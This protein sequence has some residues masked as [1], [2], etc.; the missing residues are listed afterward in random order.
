[1][2]ESGF[3][4]IILGSAILI[5]IIYGFIVRHNWNPLKF[6]PDTFIAMFLIAFGL[7]QSASSYG[8]F[9][10]GAIVLLMLPFACAISNNSFVYKKVEKSSIGWLV[11]GIIL[12]ALCFLYN[13]GHRIFG[14]DAFIFDIIVVLFFAFSVIRFPGFHRTVLLLAFSVWSTFLFS[15]AAL[16]SSYILVIMGTTIF[17]RSYFTGA[18]QTFN[19][20]DFRP[21]DIIN[22]NMYPF[23]ILD[24]SGRIIYANRDFLDFS[25]YGE[26]DLIGKEAIE[27]IEIP[28]NWMLKISP[29]GGRKKIRCHLLCRD[30]RRLPI[31]LW[32]NEIKKHGKELKN[33]ICFIY[34]ESEHQAMELK[35]N[36][37]AR[38]FSGLH[39]TSRAISSSLEMK[40]VL[41]AIASAAEALTDSDTCTV[42]MLDHSKQVVKP[43]YS[44]EQV[45]SDE[46][47]NFEF[48]VGQ[49]LTGR[50]IADGKPRLQNYDDETD[51]AVLVPGTSDEEESILSAPLLAKNIVIGALT[52]YKTGGKKFDEENLQT[53]TVFASQAASALETSRLYMKLKES[54]KVYRASVDLA[55]DSI[56]FI[57]SETG[58]IKDANETARRLLGYSMAEIV[59]RH[60]WELHPQPRMRIARQ[61]WQSVKNKGRDMIPEIEFESKDGRI[62]QASINASKIATGD[63]DFIQWVVRD[64]S[65]YK[66]II[67]KMGFFHKVLRDL[68][69][70]VLITEA[71][72]I[73][74]FANDSFKRLFATDPEIGDCLANEKTSIMSLRLPLLD[75]IWGNLKGKSGYAHDLIFN[76]GRDNQVARTVHVLPKYDSTAKLTHFFWIFHPVLT[77]MVSARSCV[78]GR[79]GLVLSISACIALASQGPIQISMVFSS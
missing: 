41:E 57:D 70:P 49:G 43:L 2:L 78:W 71:E 27:L 7:I 63:N 18:Y 46:V 52:L 10:K 50:V 3:L 34:D 38:R 25:G 39:E 23:M 58:R 42:F 69:D 14:Y 31:L 17:V 66:R 35:I 62:I 67:D 60:V 32:L 64:M 55:G 44:T 40:D 28:G 24:L 9:H 4:D 47:M 56:M 59:A 1:M 45:Y 68:S 26:R 30:G 79:G 13:R 73:I 6:A 72:G 33:L 54:E 29:L 77:R 75:E 8:A 19:N 51:L 53:L 61:L 74:C 16:L 37:E 22:A 12:M 20:L 65:E 36:A 11:S 15:S 21:D 5:R 76:S 48:S